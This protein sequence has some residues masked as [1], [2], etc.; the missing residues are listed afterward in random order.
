MVNKSLRDKA[1][2]IIYLEDTPRPHECSLLGVVCP[3]P[4]CH[5]FTLPVPLTMINQEL[6]LE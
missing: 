5:T 1:L 6:P 2:Q 3:S 4:E